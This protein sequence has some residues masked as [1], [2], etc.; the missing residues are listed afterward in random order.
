VTVVHLQ[1]P[2]LPSL[3]PCGLL[4][5]QWLR[6]AVAPLA[7][8]D[9]ATVAGS[10]SNTA[11]GGSAVYSPPSVS[12]PVSVAHS[13]RKSRLLEIPHYW[14]PTSHA[15]AALEARA[16][17]RACLICLQV[18]DAK[19]EYPKGISCCQ[20]PFHAD[21]LAPYVGAFVAYDPRSEAKQATQPNKKCPHCQRPIQQTSMSRLLPKLPRP[22]SPVGLPVSPPSSPPDVG[23]LEYVRA[24]PTSKV[25]PDGLRHDATTP[26]GPGLGPVWGGGNAP[27]A[28]SPVEFVQANVAVVRQTPNGLALVAPYK[29]RANWVVARFGVGWRMLLEEWP[30]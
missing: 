13:S 24:M 27:G 14:L 29:V 10:G 30:A 22:A 7:A 3:G 20:M 16:N 4:L 17:S 2:A 11:V 19:G 28:S 18:V 12:V 6:S 5:H 25:D 23:L 15:G 26:L 9:Q 8:S 21:C 1:L